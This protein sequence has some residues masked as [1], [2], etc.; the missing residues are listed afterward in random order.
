MREEKKR[1]YSPPSDFRVNVEAGLR[2]A[3]SAGLAFLWLRLGPH[4]NTD[5]SLSFFAAVAGIVSVGNSAGQTIARSMEM[6]HGAMIGAICAVLPGW[7]MQWG[8]L[9]AGVGFFVAIFLVVR[10]RRL[11]SLGKKFGSLCVAL[12][13]M[14]NVS[15]EGIDKGWRSF[16]WSFMRASIEGGVFALA[17]SLLPYP[18]FSTEDAGHRAQFMSRSLSHA[19]HSCVTGFTKGRDEVSISRARLLCLQVRENLRVVRM[20]LKWSRLELG[21]LFGGFV[22]GGMRTVDAL[23]ELADLMEQVLQ[24]VR[25]LRQSLSAMHRTRA[26]ASFAAAIGSSLRE[27]AEAVDES[28]EAASKRTTLFSSTLLAYDRQAYRHSGDSRGKIIVNGNINGNVNG[29]INGDINGDVMGDINGNVNGNIYGNVFGD[30]NGDIN[31]T[32]NN[33]SNSNISGKTINRNKIEG[34]YRKSLNVVNTRRDVERAEAELRLRN[35]H[36]AVNT[37]RDIERADAELSNDP[38]RSRQTSVQ[39]ATER[40]EEAVSKLMSDYDRARREILYGL[41]ELGQP[42]D[43]SDEGTPS[44]ARYGEG[45]RGGGGEEGGGRQGEG[46]GDGRGGGGVQREGGGGAGG[47]GA[48]GGGGG[49][50]GGG[51]GGAKGGAGAAVDPSREVPNHLLV[52]KE[53]QQLGSSA[54]MARG[55][56]LFSLGGLCNHLTED[57]IVL[58][59]GWKASHS[60]EALLFALS[61]AWEAVRP[62]PGLLNALRSG[63][64]RVASC[65]L[66][67]WKRSNKSARHFNGDINGDDGTG[68]SGGGGGSDSGSGRHFDSLDVGVD[69]GGDGDGD[70]RANGGDCG[71]NSDR[72]S[73]PAKSSSRSAGCWRRAQKSPLFWSFK[74]SMALTIC[75]AFR[76]VSYLDRVFDPSVWI[77]VT[78]C[79]I[80]EDQ[81]ASAVATSLLRLVG[82]VLGAVYGIVAAKISIHPVQDPYNYQAH[83]ILLPWVAMTCFFRNSADYGYAAL[84][85]AF[86]AVIMFTGSIT[87]LGEEGV[88]VSLA[89]IVNTV[90][91]SVIYLLVD[92]LLVPRRAKALVL[93]HTYASL[94]AALN[95]SVG[96]GHGSNGVVGDGGRGGDLRGDGGNEGDGGVEGYGSNG[97]VRDGGEEG[98]NVRGRGYGNARTLEEGWRGGDARERRYGIKRAVGEE[99][100]GADAGEQGYGSSGGLVDGRRRGGADV[101]GTTWGRSFVGGNTVGQK[102]I[103]KMEIALGFQKQYLPLADL[104]PQLWYKPFHAS[105]YQG[106][107]DAQEELLRALTLMSKAAIAV[108]E[109]H[110]TTWRQQ[111]DELGSH[112]SSLVQLLK[113]GLEGARDAFGSQDLSEAFSDGDNVDDIINHG[114]HLLD[115]HAEAIGLGSTVNTD[116]VKFIQDFLERGEFPESELES[117]LRINTAVISVMG[118]QRALLSLGHAVASVLDRE[119]FG[120]YYR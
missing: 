73:A 19:V 118:L 113:V 54:T 22:G 81:S 28:L 55:A 37:R 25:G 99:G 36:S 6:T 116:F 102:F 2:T 10:S 64:R 5:S 120:S 88:E 35:R 43:S 58:T 111:L 74:V 40:L 75:V 85:A 92:I 24:G 104:E 63:A 44:E 56:F 65:C 106:M 87:V 23:D 62:P 94:D 34:R 109:D 80:M 16:T 52:M 32:I 72:G 30:I 50:E 42:L 96:Y 79:F 15:D 97:V 82:T 108:S 91:G 70:S 57:R 93:E 9:P 47:G 71:E 119:L 46:G 78:A 20:E 115:V 110:S 17:A 26:Q 61:G 86:T 33:N 31:G 83:A 11:S 12:A 51:G 39:E 21:L 117:I 8:L 45:S 1:T 60:V 103:K 38:C 100:K 90:M 89:R 27:V 84:V 7:L 13:S 107:V 29:D 53:R 69:G 105:A 95:E 18:R 76:L 59:R 114:T 4:R 49:A 68:G 48:E 41:D 77:V 101:G 3:L 66:R 14:A 98:E 67:G 112:L